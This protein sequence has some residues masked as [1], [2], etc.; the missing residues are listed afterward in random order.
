M[1]LAY[2]MQ[3]RLDAQGP[4]KFC[5]HLQKPSKKSAIFPDPQDVVAGI[6]VIGLGGPGLGKD[7]IFKG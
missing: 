7:R 3:G 1:D 5:R 6:L 2:V 4:G